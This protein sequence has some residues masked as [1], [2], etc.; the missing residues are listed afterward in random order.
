MTAATLHV[1]LFGAVRVWRAGQEIALGSAPARCLLGYLALSRGHGED[2]GRLAATLWDATDDARARQNLRQTLHVIGAT[3][4]KRWPGI[5]A[6]RFKVAL[7]PGVSTDIGNVL[8][9]L[10]AGR[11]PQVLLDG[12]AAPGRLL[13]GEPSRGELFQS[14]LRLQRD[15]YEAR[16]RALLRRI[17]GAETD[18]IAERAAEALLLID[19]AD[20]LAVR[21]LMRLYHSSGQTARA[22]AIYD[23]LWRHLETDYDS[24]PDPETQSL[25]VA[26]KSSAVPPARPQVPGRE[27]RLRIGLSEIAPTGDMKLDSVARLFRAELASTML[28][29][30]EF[31]LVDMRH[32]DDRVDYV[33]TLSAGMDDRNF[34]IVI[35][36]HR[37]GDGV[38]RWTDRWQEVGRGWLAAQ[39]AVVSRLSSSLS[40]QISREHLGV[41][42]RADFGQSAFDAWLLG[43]M[44]LDEF[45]TEGWQAA[46]A[47]FQ[48]VVDLA[49]DTSM[50]YSGL[51][52]VK[53]SRHL[54]SPGLFRE[55]GTHLES[56][57][58]AT[59]AVTLDPTD[60]RAHL[61]RGWACCLLGEHDQAAASYALARACNPND[62]WTMLSSGLGA[63]FSDDL[64]LARPLARR[65]LDEGWTTMPFQ[66]GFHAPIRFLDGDYEGCVTACE[67][68]GD[69]IMNIPAWRAAALWHLG[70]TGPARAAWDE[71][72]AL[73]RPAW[74]D[75]TTPTP[76]RMRDWLLS[77]FP[78]R[79]ADR[80]ALLAA[81]VSG[82]AGL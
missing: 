77:C 71:F 65:V 19:P 46:E 78:I 73:V 9:E 52:R 70:R 81:G 66:W 40:L 5:S 10:D 75:G 8:L 26:I 57:A 18:S 56:K 36:L 11:V 53:N 17:M 47:C 37:K 29:F 22:I 60:S 12:T 59:K 80:M 72:E 30:R 38:V 35:M 14:W 42:A 39:A 43:N 68:C 74:I 24:E 62:P 7:E 21:Y 28:R 45:R 76:D 3:L 63:A 33:L 4:G 1:D 31:E 58:L 15:A 16:A 82:A 54:M 32:T 67:S 27:D 64:D 44:R 34:L 55:A 23:R 13:D 48:R 6:D 69:A 2:R 51:A 49:P 20:E 25:V 61:H 41:I 79:S 50:G